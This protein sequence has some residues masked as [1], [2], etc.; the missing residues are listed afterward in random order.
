MAAARIGARETV[1]TW[2]HWPVATGI[3]LLTM[4]KRDVISLFSCMDLQ[5]RGQPSPR[6][7]DAK[8]AGPELCLHARRER[9]LIVGKLAAL[10]RHRRHVGRCSGPPS[11]SSFHR[12]EQGQRAGFPCFRLARNGL[13]Q[14]SAT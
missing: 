6:P 11:T 10:R 4:M 7:A 8:Y 13:W 14:R 1:S 12:V 9:L 2:G 5:F 3:E